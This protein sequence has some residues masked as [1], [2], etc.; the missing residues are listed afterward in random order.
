MKMQDNQQYEQLMLNYNQLL[1]SSKEIEKMI[2]NDDYDTALSF[3][4]KQRDIFL[5][6][7]NILS[8]LELTIEQQQD[9]ARIKQELIDITLSNMEKIKSYMSNIQGELAKVKNMQKFQN[10]YGAA[11]DASGSILDYNE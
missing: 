2:E 10:A 4:E 5:N 7:N 8:Y 9:V 3:V 11:M 1:N 6:C